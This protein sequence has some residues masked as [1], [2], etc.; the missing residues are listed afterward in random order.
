VFA[1]PEPTVVLEREPTEQAIPQGLGDGG[2]CATTQPPVLPGG[3]RTPSAP[4]L[5]RLFDLSEAGVVE[6]GDQQL[7]AIAVETRA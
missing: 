2:R 6:L 4:R 3:V 7:D 1:S 5:P